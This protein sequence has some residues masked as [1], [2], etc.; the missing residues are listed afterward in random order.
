[1]PEGRSIG[2]LKHSD[3]MSAGECAVEVLSVISCPHV[4]RDGEDGAG[5]GGGAAGVGGGVHC[6]GVGVGR[7]GEEL[8]RPVQVDYPHIRHVSHHRP[9][10]QP[11]HTLRKENKNTV[12]FV[13]FLTLKG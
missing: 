12:N 9:A 1:M 6:G 10:T 11:L 2:L 7:E 4:D 5:G 8:Q 13:T 3:T